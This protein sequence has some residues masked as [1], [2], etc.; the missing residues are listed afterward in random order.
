MSRS[1]VAFVRRRNSALMSLKLSPELAGVEVGLVVDILVSGGG[2]SD[3]VGVCFADSYGVALL[4]L[5]SVRRSGSSGF[6]GVGYTIS[7]A[8]AL[9]GLSHD[10]MSH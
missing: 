2:V 9:C 1:L 4:E 8:F 10:W 3:D 5:D 6:S 7:L